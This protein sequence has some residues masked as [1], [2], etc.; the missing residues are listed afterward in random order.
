[1]TDD[2][3]ILTNGRKPNSNWK[4]ALFITVLI[5]TIIILYHSF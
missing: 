5:I 2:Y 3:P 4:A 1:M